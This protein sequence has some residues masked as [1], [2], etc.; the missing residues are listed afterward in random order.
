MN[1]TTIVFVATI[2]GIGLVGSSFLYSMGGRS[3]KVIRRVGASLVLTLTVLGTGYLMGRGNLYVLA[4]FPMLFIGYCLP[5]GAE[6]I[7]TKIGKRFVYAS[8]VIFAG[9]IICAIYKGNTWWLLIPHFG[10]GM[11]S[12]FFGVKNP[13]YAAAEEFFVSMVLNLVLISY[14]FVV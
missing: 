4:I 9:V 5:Y 11:F 7:L 13:L 10:I 6:K 3:K 2:A 1:E 14:V 12:I 8:A